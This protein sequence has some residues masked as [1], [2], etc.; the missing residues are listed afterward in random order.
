MV[1]IDNLNVRFLQ[2][3]ARNYIFVCICPR[4]TLNSMGIQC[5]F[6]KAYIV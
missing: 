2:R 3:W 5:A 1:H 4:L 6:A